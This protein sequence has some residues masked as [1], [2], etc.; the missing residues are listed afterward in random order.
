MPSPQLSLSKVVIYTVIIN[1]VAYSFVKKLDPFNIVNKSLAHYTK[2]S[3]DFSMR[4]TSELKDKFLKE[5][6]SNLPEKSLKQ[7][8][9][10]SNISIYTIT[11]KDTTIFTDEKKYNEYKYFRD[12]NS[13]MM[14]NPLIDYIINTPALNPK[15]IKIH[16]APVKIELIKIS[17]S[18][19]ATFNAILNDSTPIVLTNN[20]LLYFSEIK[21]DRQDWMKFHSNWIEQQTFPTRI[22]TCPH[23]PRSN[24]LKTN[25]S[26]SL[27]KMEHVIKNAPFMNNI[28]DMKRF[29]AKSDKPNIFF[30]FWLNASTF[31]EFIKSDMYLTVFAPEY[32]R[33]YRSR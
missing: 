9:F 3:D 1:A 5:I 16:I 2:A 17:N 25:K 33:D 8:Y 24:G 27:T 14:S 21:E 15:N 30:C 29:R 7:K 11:T 32:S 23:N 12:N 26:E 10:I 28:I 4:K 22:L 20:D 13:M 6:Q 31:E 18:K 19:E